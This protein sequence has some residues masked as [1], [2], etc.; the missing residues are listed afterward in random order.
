MGIF[1]S[2]LQTAITATAVPAARTMQTFFDETNDE[3]ECNRIARIGDFFNAPLST[4]NGDL[5]KW[6][7]DHFPR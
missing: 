7:D 6:F 5:L 1:S 2:A 4:F 3:T